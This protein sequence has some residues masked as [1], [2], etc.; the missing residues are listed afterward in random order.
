MKKNKLST[1][2]LRIR[3]CKNINNSLTFDHSSY[4]DIGMINGL[5]IPIIATALIG[6]EG[7]I[8]QYL[9]MS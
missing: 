2:F 6:Y 9:L 3:L 4:L 1:K 8:S 7:M 5:Y